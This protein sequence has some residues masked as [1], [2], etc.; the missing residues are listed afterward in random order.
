MTTLGENRARYEEQVP[1]DPRPSRFSPLY[2]EWA[3]RADAWAAIPAHLG[4]R[5]SLTRSLRI[6]A[7]NAVRLER[8]G[9]E[10]VNGRMPGDTLYLV[11]PDGATPERIAEFK[12]SVEAITG[13][14]IDLTA[15]V[16]AP[17][18]RAALRRWARA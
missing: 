17:Y 11:L 15:T 18:L 5:D 1:T 6:A 7:I 12:A 8:S 13:R 4:A 14:Q 10:R 9:L 3:A 16:P 2:T